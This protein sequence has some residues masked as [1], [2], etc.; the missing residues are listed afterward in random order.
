MS[1]RDHKVMVR[2]NAKEA[3]RLDEIRGT[4]PRAV[5]LRRL[6]QEP[7]KDDEVATRREALALLSGLARDGKVTAT[8]ALARELRGD[9]G[10]EDAWKAF[11]LRRDG[12]S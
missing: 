3:A 7:P 9:A 6:L 2:L 5:Y 1:P 12:E 4:A 8:I 10:E 11:G